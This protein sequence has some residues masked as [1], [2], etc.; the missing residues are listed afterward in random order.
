MWDNNDVSQGLAPKG[1]QG[2]DGRDVPR[3]EPMSF[4]I[5]PP[6]RFDIGGGGYAICTFVED[7]EDNFLLGVPGLAAVRSGTLEKAVHG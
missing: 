2:A 6:I 7:L 3:G 1:G 5:T 4:D